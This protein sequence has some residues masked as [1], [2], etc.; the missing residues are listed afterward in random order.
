MQRRREDKEKKN[1]F[2][3]VFGSSTAA[4]VFEG[5]VHW[6]YL[7][8]QITGGDSSEGQRKRLF[9]ASLA[10]IPDNIFL[11]NHRIS[12]WLCDLPRK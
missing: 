3:T 5:P 9:D 11:L 12:C 1:L 7:D 6:L 10:L 8:N 4:A 2:E